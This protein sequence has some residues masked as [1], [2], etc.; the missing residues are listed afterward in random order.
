MSD[1]V[2][3]NGG[4]Q[5]SQAEK[6]EIAERFKAEQA[7]KFKQRK[8]AKAEF[9]LADAEAKDPLQSANCEGPASK[10]QRVCKQRH[11]TGHRTSHEI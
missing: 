6:L 7:E 10:R 2:A 3:K 9:A 5:L 11:E 4:G 8:A 1:E